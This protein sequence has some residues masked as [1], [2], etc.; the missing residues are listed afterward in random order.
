[1]S[2]VVVELP[3]FHPQPLCAK[4]GWNGATVEYQEAFHSHNGYQHRNDCE[5][6]CLPERLARKCGR[7]GFKW[8][9]A[10]A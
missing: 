1:M 3:P 7:C 8:D 4:C 10:V 9:E 2:D 6:G 5:P